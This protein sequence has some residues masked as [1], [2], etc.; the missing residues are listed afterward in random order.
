MHKESMEFME[1]F[2]RIE[3]NISPLAS[4]HLKLKWLY[5][6]L[7]LSSSSRLH[8]AYSILNKSQIHKQNGTENWIQMKNVKISKED[9][10]KEI[11]SNEKL[12]KNK[13]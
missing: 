10:S 4:P 9:S 6:F 1:R 8:F 5:S 2:I 13:C 12:R 7:R 3:S 11:K